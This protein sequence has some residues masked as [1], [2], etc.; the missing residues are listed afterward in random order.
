MAANLGLE[1]LDSVR[2][3][4]ALDELRATF[5]VDIQL[6]GNVIHAGRQFFG[7]VV[8]VYCGQHRVGG[9]EPAFSGCL[10]NAFLYVLKY[11]AIFFLSQ[12][13]TQFLD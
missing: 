10:E 6:T 1:I 7:C 9:N 5:R 8:P 2:F 12:F 4:H 3:L 11:T 13:G